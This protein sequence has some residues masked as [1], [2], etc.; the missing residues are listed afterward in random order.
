MSAN[1]EANVYD[2]V[3]ETNQNKHLFSKVKLNITKEW[4]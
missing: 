2:I 4:I 1:V 3:H